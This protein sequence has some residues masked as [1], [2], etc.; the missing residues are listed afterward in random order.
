MVFIGGHPAEYWP[1]Y[2]VAYLTS[3]F[4]FLQIFVL[5]V[6]TVTVTSASDLFF[7][8]L[9]HVNIRFYQGNWILL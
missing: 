6:F 4:I 1:L 8:K 5:I 2:V 3:L 9:P 7:L